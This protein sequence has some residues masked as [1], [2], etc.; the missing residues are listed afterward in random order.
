MALLRASASPVFNDKHAELMN[1]EDAP[2]EFKIP[3]GYKVTIRAGG[4]ILELEVISGEFDNLKATAMRKDDGSWEV[5]VNRP[6]GRMVIIPPIYK[7]RTASDPIDALKMVNSDLKNAL[8]GAP[9]DGMKLEDRMADL[10]SNDGLLEDMHTY[11]FNDTSLPTELRN[12]YKLPEG[13]AFVRRTSSGGYGSVFITKK[14]AD[15]KTDINSPIAEVSGVVDGKR[16]ITVWANDADRLAGAVV[17]PN[18][19]ALDPEHAIAVVSSDLRSAIQGRPAR[20]IKQYKDLGSAPASPAPATPATPA[21]AT[22]SVPADAPAL[23]EGY[24]LRGG[25][26]DAPTIVRSNDMSKPY[27]RIEKS[28]DE[29]GNV[30][31]KGKAWNTGKDALDDLSPAE[32]KDFTDREKAMKWATRRAEDPSRIGKPDEPETKWDTDADGREVLT[33]TGIEGSED[34]SNPAAFITDVPGV[35]VLGAVYNKKSGIGGTPYEVRTFRSRDEAKEWASNLINGELEKLKNGEES[36][37]FKNSKDSEGMPEAITKDFLNPYLNDPDIMGPAPLSGSRSGAVAEGLLAKQDLY[38]LGKTTGQVLWLDSVNLEKRLKKEAESV[39]FSPMVTEEEDLKKFRNEWAQKKAQQIENFVRYSNGRVALL[40]EIRQNA[41]VDGVFDEER[42]NKLMANF[43]FAQNRIR[44]RIERAKVATNIKLPLLFK[45]LDAATPQDRRLKNQFETRT[46]NGHAAFDADPKWG[47]TRRSAEWRF[48]NVD[49]T[50]TDDMRTKYGF[51]LNNGVNGIGEVTDFNGPEDVIGYKNVTASD[52]RQIDSE[53][54]Q[55]MKAG[56]AYQ[57]G[58]VTM[59]MKDSTKNR[60]TVTFTDSLTST[61]TAMPMLGF[62]DEQ[63]WNAGW[64]DKVGINANGTISGYGGGYFEIQMNGRI[65]LEDVEAIYAS[66]AEQKRQIE[67]KLRA[68]G[69][70]IP[71]NIKTRG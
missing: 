44:D 50:V 32:E 62:T 36:D 28:T 52:R 20:D 71:V 2:E 4:E 58:D 42:H 26:G 49:L 63:M 66:N 45:L 47:M 7:N 43:I 16:T 39:D 55:G 3:N 67:S 53:L 38:D 6:A 70:G 56:S 12:R 13:Y 27:M 19:D 65:G 25:E 22:P 69:I 5:R 9:H 54:N 23:P 29:N 60:T 18:R 34:D 21:P 64:E 40:L 57:Y 8:V 1:R 33:V 61:V 31:F 14:D 11:L 37:L 30:I 68:L 17:Y 15:G 51:P 46:T 41:H 35:G 59:V 48:G 24:S 10:T